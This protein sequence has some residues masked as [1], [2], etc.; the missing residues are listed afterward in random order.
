MAIKAEIFR[1]M[2]DLL[3]RL[4]DSLKRADYT[5]NGAAEKGSPV[6]VHLSLASIYDIHVK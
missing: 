2:K 1:G 5:G 3:I 6:L 4:R